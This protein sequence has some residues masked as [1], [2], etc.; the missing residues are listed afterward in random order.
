MQPAGLSDF[1]AEFTP[2][3]AV[4]AFA[5]IGNRRRYRFREAEGRVETPVYDRADLPPPSHSMARR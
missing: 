4:F 2:S 1:A 3:E 5:A